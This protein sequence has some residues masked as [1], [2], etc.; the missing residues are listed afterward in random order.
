MA[1]IFKSK[2]IKHEFKELIYEI[3]SALNGCKDAKF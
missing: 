3:I 1:K 2:E